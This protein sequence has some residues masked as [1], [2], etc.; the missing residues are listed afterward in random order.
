MITPYKV[1]RTS[2]RYRL[3]TFAMISSL[4]QSVLL[5]E[6]VVGLCL[7]RI[8]KTGPHKVRTGGNRQWCI[9]CNFLRE[10]DGLAAQIFFVR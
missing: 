2:F 5:D 8:G 3:N 7:D 9:L 10:F 4:L 6:L 1:A